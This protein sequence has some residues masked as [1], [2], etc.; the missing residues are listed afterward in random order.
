MIMKNNKNLNKNNKNLSKLLQ[1][2]KISY[3]VWLNL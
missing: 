3:L 1:F 2:Q